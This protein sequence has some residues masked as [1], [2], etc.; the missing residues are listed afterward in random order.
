MALAGN[1]WSNAG[2][3]NDFPVGNVVTVMCISATT[4]GVLTLLIPRDT[5]WFSYL[6][7]SARFGIALGLSNLA[8]ERFYGNVTGPCSKTKIES[9]SFLDYGW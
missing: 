4:L 6:Y 1:V 8:G 7:A 5:T 2:Q 9:L 3:S